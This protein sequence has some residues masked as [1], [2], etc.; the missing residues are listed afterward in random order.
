MV[1]R[2]RSVLRSHL[3]LGNLKH[4]RSYYRLDF[5]FKAPTFVF[6]QLVT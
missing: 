3:R 2:L 1:D 4:L 5:G 6:P